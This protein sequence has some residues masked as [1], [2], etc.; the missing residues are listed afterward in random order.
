MRRVNIHKIN[1]TNAER[2]VD[3]ALARGEYKLAPKE[4]QERI[5]TMI[6]AYQKDAVLN[7]RINSLD[8]QCLKD[9][10][11]KL[12]VKYQTFVSQILHRVAQS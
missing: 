11:K 10:A 5:A 2:E 4:E 8:L 9:K 1:L 3:E 6:K 12:G 7:I